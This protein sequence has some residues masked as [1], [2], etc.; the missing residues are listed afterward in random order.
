ME[1]VATVQVIRIRVFPEIRIAV[2]ALLDMIRLQGVLSV[3]VRSVTD[4]HQT[5]TMR[6]AKPAS[7]RVSLKT[8]YAAPPVCMHCKDR[9]IVPF[10]T[11]TPIWECGSGMTHHHLDYNWKT[12]EWIKWTGQ[13]CTSIGQYRVLRFEEGTRWRLTMEELLL[14]RDMIRPLLHFQVFLWIGIRK[15]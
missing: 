8:S 11:S 3:S 13:I 2:T 12:T 15:Q 7:S 1:T 6:F 10:I 9:P 5:A 14:S 4:W